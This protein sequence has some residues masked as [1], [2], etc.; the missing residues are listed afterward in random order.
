MKELEQIVLA[1]SAD[2][3]LQEAVKEGA[4]AFKELL[5]MACNIDFKNIENG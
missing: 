4:E 3:N 1:M 2:N 5:L